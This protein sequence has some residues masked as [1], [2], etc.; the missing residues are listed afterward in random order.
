MIWT[1]HGAVG[2]SADWLGFADSMRGRLPK[3]G[4]SCEEVR[5]IDLWRFLDC[6]PMPLSEVGGAIAGQIRRID[7]EP[8]LVGY[9]MGG[10]LALHALLEDPDMWKS[11]VIVSAHPGLKDESQ[12][13]TRR[14][15]DA[16]WAAL[17]LKGAWSEFLEKWESQ[18]VLGGAGEMLDRRALK[19]RRGSVARSFIDWSLGAQEDLSPRLGEVRCPVLWVTGE[20]DQKFTAL[21]KEAV[22]LM[23]DAVHEVVS[24]CGHRVPWEQSEVFADLCADFLNR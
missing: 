8:V 13:A 1:L 4:A 5:R 9:S 14:L 11:A 15:S 2:R 23:P 20:R 18:G 22:S 3:V 6:C 17:A 19:S 21:G 24:D 10:R 16:E 7:P 12:R